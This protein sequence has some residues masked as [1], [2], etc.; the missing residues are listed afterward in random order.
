M[1]NENDDDELEKDEEE[2]EEVDDAESE[3]DKTSQNRFESSD[4][5]DHGRTASVFV[6]ATKTDKS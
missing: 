6:H 4:I 3:S 1:R 5:H 2:E